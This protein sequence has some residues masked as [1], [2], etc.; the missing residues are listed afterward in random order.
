MRYSFG[1]IIKSC[2]IS[3]ENPRGS[4]MFFLLSANVLARGLVRAE[5]NEEVDVS[6]SVIFCIRVCV[7]FV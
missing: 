2:I 1:G 7:Y 6:P 4:P 3:R 5:Y